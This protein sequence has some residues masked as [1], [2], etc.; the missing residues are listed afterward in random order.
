MKKVPI[1]NAV[2]VLVII[3]LFS[4]I[5]ME[6][7]ASLINVWDEALYAN[8]ALQMKHNHE[9]LT[10]YNYGLVDHHNTKPPLVLWLEVLSFHLWGVSEF[11]VRFPTY[12]S[13]LGLCIVVSCW[14]KQYLRTYVPGLI[15]ALLIVSSRFL[16]QRHLFLTGDLDGI[17]VFLES[18]L[19]LYALSL[20]YRSH[21]DYRWQEYFNLFLLFFLC[22]LCKSTSILLWIPSLV[23]IFLS[24]GRLL[25]FI[26]SKFFWAGLCITCLLIVSYYGFRAYK[27]PAYWSVVWRTEFLRAAV[28]P[29]PWFDWKRDF[30]YQMFLDYERVLFWLLLGGM[31]VLLFFRRSTLRSITFTLFVA[32]LLFGVIISLSP[33]KMAYYAAPFYPL[34][35]VLTVLCWWQ[36]LK[37]VFRSETFFRY[38]ALMAFVLAAVI[39]TGLRIRQLIEYLPGH[40]KDHSELENEAYLYHSLKQQLSDKRSVIFFRRTDPKFKHHDDALEFYVLKSRHTQAQPLQL[41]DSLRPGDYAIISNSQY[42]EAAKNEYHIRILDSTAVGVFVLVQ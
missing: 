35:Y 25:T 24:G 33:S 41:S 27:D 6:N 39:F 29:Q 31:A 9:W 7:Q 22:W 12:V 1:L 42:F 14:T 15:C 21:A 40:L 37:A 34:F 20:A 8:N 28:N 23:F 5:L 17:L 13:L 19:I 11:A 30:Y 18:C 2:L 32:D 16:I 38:G 26:R 36:L 3:A 10:Y 4:V